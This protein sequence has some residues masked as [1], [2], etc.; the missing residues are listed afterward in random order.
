MSRPRRSESPLTGRY[1]FRALTCLDT[2]VRLHAHLHYLEHRGDRGIA[3][4]RLDS[5]EH[6]CSKTGKVVET[7]I[8]DQRNS[9]LRLSRR[10][11]YTGSYTRFA[12]P[13]EAHQEIA[14]DLHEVTLGDDADQAVVLDDRQACDLMVAHQGDGV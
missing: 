10:P 7:E 6:S 14:K 3:V 4:S 8:I 5:M 9:T 1:G 2:C 12:R 11:I 13:Q